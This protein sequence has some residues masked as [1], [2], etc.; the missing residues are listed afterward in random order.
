[1]NRPSIFI[2]TS[3]IALAPF[4]AMAEGRDNIVTLVVEND[5]FGGNGTDQ[6]YSS[7][8]R[9]GYIDINSEFPQF[10]HEIADVV[11][12]F[13]IN[14]TSSIFYSVGQNIYT[15]KIDQREQDPDD[16]PWAAFLYG[17]IGMVTFTDNHSDEIEA[18]LGVIG[19]AA[20]GEPVQKAIHRHVSGSPTPKGWSNQLENEPGLM[21]A[22]QRA[23]PRY[24]AGTLG[25]LY[26]SA[27]PYYGV[28]LG[29]VMTNGSTGINARIGPASEKWQDTPLRVRPAMPGTGFFEIPENKWS[30]YVFGG[31]EGRAVAR[32]IFLDGNTFQDSHDVDKNYVVG[33]ANAGLAFTYGQTRISYTLN[34]R[35]KEFKTQD[36]PELFGAVSLGYRF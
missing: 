21:L 15:P 13:D 33:D 9:L 19:P 10:A 23:W 32:N 34:Y 25:S 35:S 22:W 29:N 1:M 2:F 4:S 14:E 17:S 11:P 20:L 8:I 24:F 26:W 16:R 27:A 18:T 3:C 31:I 30:W 28:T 7:G 5:L 36:K 6:N 12:M